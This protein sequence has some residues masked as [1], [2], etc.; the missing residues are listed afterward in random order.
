MTYLPRHMR[1]PYFF[2]T[3]ECARDPSPLAL[4]SACRHGQGLK[5][6]S[7]GH[8]TTY[9]TPRN[10]DRDS[11]S[12]YAAF[13]LT[14]H[15]LRHGAAWLPFCPSQSPALANLNMASRSALGARS[16]RLAMRPS[17]LN[18]ATAADSSLSPFLPS[19]ARYFSLSALLSQPL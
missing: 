15:D 5:T 2:S 12:S 1:K 17:P 14:R 6:T 19:S 16:R 3:R 18:V 10:V 7:L 4:G 11:H 8:S 9:F 13:A